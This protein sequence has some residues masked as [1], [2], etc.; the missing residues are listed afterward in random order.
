MF[1]YFA[2]C[3]VVMPLF[4]LIAFVPKCG[5]RNA[6]VQVVTSMGFV[7]GL[8]LTEE[9]TTGLALTEEPTFHNVFKLP[10]NRSVPKNK[11]TLH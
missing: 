8:A 1:G 2:D 7:T 3:T 11:V 10:I 9:P 5:R 4:L 6:E